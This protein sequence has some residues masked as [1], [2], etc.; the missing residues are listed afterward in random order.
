MSD[1]HILFALRAN[2]IRRRT[3]GKT[4]GV[5]VWRGS[6]IRW[7]VLIRLR[8][9]ARLG[10]G[11]VLLMRRVCSILPRIAG[12]AVPVQSSRW[13]GNDGRAGHRLYAVVRLGASRSI[14]RRDVRCRGEIRCM[15][16]G[17]G[18]VRSRVGVYPR[19]A[20]VCRHQLAWRIVWRTQRQPCRRAHAGRMPESLRGKPLQISTHAPH[21]CR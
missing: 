17:L 9:G 3:C 13:F 19:N 1:G 7:N 20:S 8:A 14:S 2:T 15:R 12:R 10:S 6:R 4:R 5:R 16:G 11:L 21:R 18:A